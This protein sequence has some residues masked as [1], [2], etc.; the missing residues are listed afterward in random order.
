M[1]RSFQ[2]PPELLVERNTF[3]SSVSVP[4]ERRLPEFAAIRPFLPEPVL[5]QDPG[6]E[7]LYWSAWEAVWT[8][9]RP[10]APGSM[11]VSPFPRPAEGANL[12]MEASSFVAHLAGYLPGMPHLL[13]ILDNFYARQHDDGF[14]C[15]ALDAETG[16]DFHLPY[17]PNSSGPSLM[18][19]AEWRHFRLSGN[20]GRIAAAFWPLLAHHRWRRANRTWPGGLYWSTAHSSGLINQPRVPGGRFHHQH[21]AWVDAS[22]QASLDAS[23]L[24]RMAVLLGETALAEEMASERA[25]LA[26]A[27]NAAMWNSETLFFH[28]VAPDGRFS[29][30]KSIAAYWALLDIQLVPKD[31]LT[32]FVQHLRDTWSFRTPYVLPSLS[33]DSEGYNARTGNGWRGAVRSPLTYMVLRGLQVTDHHTLAHQ[34]ALG[35]LDTVCSVFEESGRFWESYAPESLGPGDPACEDLS[36]QTPAVIIA[37]LLEH[38]LGLAIDWPLRQITWRRNLE[39]AEGYGVRN[40][41]LGTEGTV[42]LIS[43]GQTVRIRTDAPF[44]LFLHSSKDVFQTAIPAGSF[45]IELD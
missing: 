44:T 19:W 39:R 26:Q 8:R 21:W 36:G 30:V 3:R 4:G 35:H 41:P 10:P 25:A 27:F 29:P 37:M 5:P 13:E 1:T 16:R 2:L 9:F 28:D 33:A 15:R 11:L 31:R 32:P 14:I 6:W 43:E 40:L 45:A 17:E 38:V 12:E 22:A 23:L 24:E 34:L 7:R 42:D 20:D 18:A